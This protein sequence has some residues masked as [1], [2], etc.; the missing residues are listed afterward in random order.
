MKVY[1]NDKINIHKEK[2]NIHIFKGRELLS[3]YL[4]G[5]K[6]YVITP[7]V[8][9]RL[10]KKELLSQIEFPEGRLS[11]DILF[12]IKVFYGC[13]KALYIDMPLYFYRINRMGGISY[14]G[15][16]RNRIEDKVILSRQAIDFLGD[17]D[18][19]MAQLI[20]ENLYIWLFDMCLKVEDKTTKKYVDNCF[21]VQKTCLRDI[22]ILKKNWLKMQCIKRKIIWTIKNL[23]RHNYKIISIK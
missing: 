22:K 5:T 6:K 16:Q 9:D 11:E 15:Y 13:K 8:W 17:K 3:A 20:S 19:E 1:E 12:T 14:S 4:R 10:Y 7:A 21:D 2:I 23:K 18:P